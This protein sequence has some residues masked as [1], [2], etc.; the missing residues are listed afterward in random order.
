MKKHIRP[1]LTAYAMARALKA[2][3]LDVPKEKVG[4]HMDEK[5]VIILKTPKGVYRPE[6]EP[7]VTGSAALQPA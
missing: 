7:V 1:L 4:L 3:G 5:G 2:E 6:P